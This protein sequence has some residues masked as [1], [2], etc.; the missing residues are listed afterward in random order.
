M[1]AQ[2]HPV[3]DIRGLPGTTETLVYQDGGQFPV[4]AATPQGQL[5]A[6]LR[7]GSGHLGLAGMRER[8]LALGGDV[9]VKSSPGAGV[10]IVIRIPL[11]EAGAV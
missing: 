3:L 4:L 7:G 9:S 10:V 2:T 11:S 8:I 6:A 1:S 5:V